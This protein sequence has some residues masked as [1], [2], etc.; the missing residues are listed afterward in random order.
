MPQPTETSGRPSGGLVAVAFAGQAGAALAASRPVTWY[1]W[2][3]GGR[4]YCAQA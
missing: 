3:V 1:P 4:E 2:N